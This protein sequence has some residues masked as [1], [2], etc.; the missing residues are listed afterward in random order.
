[1][2]VT[3]L[4]DIV[5]PAEFSAYTIQNSVVS[6]A[7]SQAGVMVQNGEI[8]SQLSAGA[9]QFTAPYWN[10]LP[11]VE[12]DITNDNPAIL[13]VPQKF[14]SGAQVIRKSFLHQSF[15]QMS[16]AA[17]LSGDDPLAR[18][19]GR[20]VNYWDRQVQSRLVASLHGIINSNVA[21]NASDQVV[22]ISGNSGTA[23]NI[24]ASSVIDAALTLG[25]KL[26]DVTG[27]AMRSYVYGQLS[28][29]DLIEF[30][31]NSQGHLRRYRTPAPRL[32]GPPLRRFSRTIRSSCS[33]S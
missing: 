24:D 7:F 31:P 3:Q 1:M 18:L 19:Q 20:V 4:A 13:A 17:E 29:Q 23:A 25:D 14:T 28:K 32:H 15:S 22:D 12:A 33:R 27:I 2:S 11:D 16:L 10:D 9:T 5:I 8:A 26:E 30:I 6:S 21:N